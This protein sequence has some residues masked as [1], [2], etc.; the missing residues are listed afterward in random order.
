MAKEQPSTQARSKEQ[1]RALSKAT[2][3]VRYLSTPYAPLQH[4]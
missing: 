3:D 1:R 4:V 2:N